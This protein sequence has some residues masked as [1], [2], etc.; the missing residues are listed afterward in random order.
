[1]E[2]MPFYMHAMYKIRITVENG[3]LW[4]GLWL[5]FVFIKFKKKN[6]KR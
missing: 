6:L 5:V 2:K 1:M 4:S 3:M